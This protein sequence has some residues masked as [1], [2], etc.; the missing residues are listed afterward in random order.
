MIALEQ[1]YNSLILAYEKQEQEIESLRQQLAEAISAV[2]RLSEGQPF[3]AVVIADTVKRR[4]AQ[5]EQKL[6]DHIKREVM[7][8]NALE[9]YTIGGSNYS[10]MAQEALAA[11]D[12]MKDV[13]LCHAKPSGFEHRSVERPEIQFLE[14]R[15]DQNGYRGEWKITPLY[16]A[17]E[18]KP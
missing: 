17:W 16:R 3:D 12:D 8:R 15:S 1:N 4:T 7:L 2:T 18:P 10:K 11:T 9:H 13:I 5:L 6:A 14:K